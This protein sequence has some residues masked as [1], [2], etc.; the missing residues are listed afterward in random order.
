MPH[1]STASGLESFLQK[2]L[3]TE[4]KLKIAESKKNSEMMARDITRGALY[5]NISLQKQYSPSVKTSQ[6]DIETR[7]IETNTYSNDSLAL[8]VRQPIF[9]LKDWFN[10]KSADAKSD[11]AQLQYEA[12]YS[13]TILTGVKIY[14]DVLNNLRESNLATM[15]LSA[16]ELAK[17]NGKKKLEQGQISVQTYES[18]ESRYNLAKAEYQKKLNDFD[19]SKRL[20]GL[21]DSNEPTLRPLNATVSDKIRL[22]D[23][24]SV[25]ENNDAWKIL[26]KSMHIAEQELRKTRSE[27]YPTVD[28]IVQKSNSTS[29]SESLIGK[30]VDTSFVGFQLNLPIFSGFSTDAAV[31][32]AA[33]NLDRARLELA[34][35][36]NDLLLE[37]TTYLNDLNRMILFHSIQKQ[38]VEFAARKVKR[39]RREVDL[40]MNTELELRFAEIEFARQENM[41]FSHLSDY[42]T[43]TVEMTL[44][45]YLEK[46][47]L[48]DILASH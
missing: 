44:K 3:E 48:Q 17:S 7:R 47:N 24:S 30:Q 29:A 25:K 27:H 10:Y 36:E 18:L 9:R 32:Q 42:A 20:F 39:M 2:Y 12:L 22:R 6:E 28:L 37:S 34:N 14:F 26:Q 33:Y 43:K 35:L 4:L 13:E 38:E 8:T 23:M 40:G 21:Y 5:P 31:R 45:G 19:K 15:I 16:A 11:L 46:S 1:I 41:Y